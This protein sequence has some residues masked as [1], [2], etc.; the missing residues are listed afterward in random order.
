MS[1]LM[2][3]L[4][5]AEKAKKQAEREVESAAAQAAAAQESSS[6]GTSSEGEIASLVLDTADT[7]GK[8]ADAEAPP[9]APPEDVPE[10]GTIVFDFDLNPEK[11]ASTEAPEKPAVVA[12]EPVTEPAP[13]APD[14][15]PQPKPVTTSPSFSARTEGGDSPLRARTVFLAKKQ[16]GGRSS[17]L[18]R[19]LLTVV[20]ILIFF[21]LALSSYFGYRIFVD[22]PAGIIAI[23]EGA[24]ALSP[25]EEM[26]PSETEP[27]DG[28]DQLEPDLT[29]PV[30]ESQSPLAVEEIE[31]LP[32]EDPAPQGDT[33]VDEA[34]RAE[35]VPAVPAAV[36]PAPP[37]REESV[38]DGE[39]SH[40]I[41][42]TRRK[43]APAV[44]PSLAEAY[45]AYRH[46]DI[47][48]AERAYLDVLQSD[49]M[50][51][52]TLLGLAAIA[53]HRGDTE[54]AL[55]YYRRLLERDPGDPLALSGILSITPVS[56]ISRHISELKLLL[57]QYP[58]T[59]ALHFGLG[60]LYAARKNWSEA[61]HSYAAALAFERKSVDGKSIL[62]ADYAFN[63]AVSLEHLGRNHDALQHYKEALELAGSQLPVAFDRMIATERIAILEL[64][65]ESSAP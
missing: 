39:S 22:Q 25:P 33:F 13:I 31:R 17:F 55:V 45:D 14:P 61:H 32:V 11:G 18:S 36:A 41:V 43:A 19:T 29:E 12:A 48:R 59:A 51:R 6:P 38:A 24:P 60:N 20:L 42:I 47:G 28:G 15:E 58:E 64:Q 9:E 21:G 53:Y 4:T 40:P 30:M 7:V 8:P 65:P 46:G 49:P 26:P 2:D 54:L 62:A 16:S 57:A 23:P 5:R 34:E 1:L 3:A 44:D 37:Q 27:A 50:Q 52:S 63:L 10:N 35:T 56:D